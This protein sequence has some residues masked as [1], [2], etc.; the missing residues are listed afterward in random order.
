MY[1]AS[2]KKKKRG[3][4]GCEKE[5]KKIRYISYCL[6]LFT[7]LGSWGNKIQYVDYLATAFKIHDIYTPS[8]LINTSIHD[9]CQFV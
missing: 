1:V 8:H 7:D 3:G 5:H 9:H 4:V 6:T 2:F